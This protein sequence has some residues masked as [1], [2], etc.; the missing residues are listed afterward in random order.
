MSKFPNQPGQEDRYEIV[1]ERL[2]TTLCP[3]PG[4]TNPCHMQH[5]RYEPVDTYQDRLVILP[6]T[7]KANSKS[8]LGLE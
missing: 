8:L 2:R 5:S 6:A 7:L 4:L 3:V 1:A